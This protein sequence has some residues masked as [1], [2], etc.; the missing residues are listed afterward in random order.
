MEYIVKPL[1]ADSLVAFSTDKEPD[2]TVDCMIWT[3]N[4]AKII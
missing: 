2:K 3:L 1:R 4:T